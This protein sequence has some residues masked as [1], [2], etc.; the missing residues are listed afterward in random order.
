MGRKAAAAANVSIASNTA[1]VV[2]KAT[3]GLTTGSTAVFSEALHSLV[4]LVAAVMAR[5]AVGKSR[6]P[7]DPRHPHGHG[8]FESVSGT[9]EGMMVLG[10]AGLIWLA[11]GH[12]LATGGEVTETLPGLIAMAVSAL[13]NT[14]VSAYL[15]RVA[16]EAGSVAL[17]ADAVHLRAD[18]W[19]SLG[20]VGGLIAI[21]VTGVQE[22][23]PLV[24]IVV[25]GMIA[26]EGW[27]ISRRALGQLL[28]EALPQGDQ[29]D[30]KRVLTE[31]YGT[32]A[33]FHKL[34]SR[35]AGPQRYVDV[36]VEMCRKMLL[37]EVH[38]VCSHLEHDIEKALPGT[39]ILI[40]AEPC[41]G[42]CEG[43]ESLTD[44]P[45]W[46]R[47]YQAVQREQAARHDASAP[48]EGERP[49]PAE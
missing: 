6:Q 2:G 16:R 28:D 21:R 14:I 34:R 40:H 46:C 10:A 3:V 44:R 11:A 9:V 17:E 47:A 38:D 36:H 1:L 39:D 18:V 31:H 26:W 23:D 22:L 5:Y 45:P 25:G 35:R 41:D 49:A 7:A 33:G 29:E 43:R 30:V 48:A 4:D 19:T 15:F 42:A 13:V 27:S 37:Q 24:A 32:I 12:R 8:K 20:V